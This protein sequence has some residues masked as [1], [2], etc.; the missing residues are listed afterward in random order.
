MKNSPSPRRDANR[1][2]KYIGQTSNLEL[3]AKGLLKLIERYET[4]K[5]AKGAKKGTSFNRQQ[6]HDTLKAFCVECMNPGPESKRADEV[7]HLFRK[8][9]EALLKDQ[10]VP[11][12]V[13]DI[14]VQM[15]CF[16]L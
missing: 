1:I 15:V 5:S 6:I 4:T 7:I 2:S 14:R 3:G 13:R 10:D 12:I 11:N 9:G 16:L 8:Y